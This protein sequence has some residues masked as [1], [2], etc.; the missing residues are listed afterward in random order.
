MLV[1]HIVL[2]LTCIYC[3]I[4][5]CLSIAYSCLDLDC[6]ELQFYICWPELLPEMQTLMDISQWCPQE[7]Q[8]QHIQNQTH[9]LLPPTLMSTPLP[10]SP[11]SIN[12]N[13]PRTRNMA[14]ALSISYL[15]PCH[16][17]PLTDS[18]YQTHISPTLLTIP[19]LTTPLSPP[20]LP[21]LGNWCSLLTELPT[22]NLPPL[23]VDL[24]MVGWTN[25]LKFI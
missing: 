21:Y 22:S 23:W 6:H 13:P 9:C 16:C 24:S 12:C 11:T 1:F 8:R 4:T 5:L 10:I 14:S 7:P 2:T 25:F 18:K 17:Q 3:H 19:P 15:S 20:C